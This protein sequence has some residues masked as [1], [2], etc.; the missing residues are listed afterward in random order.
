MEIPVKY[1]SRVVELLVLKDKYSCLTPISRIKAISRRIFHPYFLFINQILSLCFIS[2]IINYKIY[3][4]GTIVT[5][6]L[7]Y[8]L[9]KFFD[10]SSNKTAL[11]LIANKY[12]YHYPSS[13]LNRFDEQMARDIFSENNIKFPKNQAVEFIDFYNVIIRGTYPKIKSHL[14][15]IVNNE[16]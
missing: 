9:T 16:K 8:L 14:K 4:T 1:Y 10:R 11:S 13:Y 3:F 15:L 12:G 5:I 7:S 2:I 6:F